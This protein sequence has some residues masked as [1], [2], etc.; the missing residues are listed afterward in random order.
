MKADAIK[1]IEFKG[2]L[3]GVR[4]RP[5]QSHI[6]DLHVLFEIIHEDDGTWAVSDAPISSHWVGDYLQVLAEA[7]A[8]MQ[9]NCEPDM[10]DGKQYGW[11]FRPTNWKGKK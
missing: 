8:W 1:P 9:K 3:V 11:N 4:L 5:R 2:E 6:N 10:H 7:Q